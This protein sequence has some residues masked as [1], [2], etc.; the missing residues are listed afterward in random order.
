MLV[1]FVPVK[2]VAVCL[3][4][5]QI[6]LDH[7]GKQDLLGHLGQ[8]LPLAVKNALRVYTVLLAIRPVQNVPV[9]DVE[10]KIYVEVLMMIVMEDGVRLPWLPP[11]GFEINTG[12]TQNPM[13]IGINHNDVEWCWG[14]RHKK[15]NRKKRESIESGSTLLTN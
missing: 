7:I 1:Q 3:R 15:R 4:I 9:V 5:F 2:A 14:G 11:E 10:G 12:V 13:A 6:P 8:S